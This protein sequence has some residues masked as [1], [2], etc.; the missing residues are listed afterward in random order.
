MATYKVRLVN[1]DQ[2]LDTTIDVP[3]D[4]YILSAAEQA[5]LE[6]PVDC[7]AGTCYTC[8]GKLM[9]GTVDQDNSNFLDAEEVEA[10]YIL[11]CVSRPTA[12]CTIETHREGDLD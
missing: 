3:G 7:R 8:V 11:T 12:D 10:G 1:A 6:L 2:G 5:G 9:A 4:Q